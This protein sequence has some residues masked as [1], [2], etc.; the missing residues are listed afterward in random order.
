MTGQS[1]LDT[2]ARAL[3]L[4]AKGLEQ[5]AFELDDKSPMELSLDEAL[6]KPK[7]RR[8]QKASPVLPQDLESTCEIC[9][10]L[11]IEEP[12]LIPCEFCGRPLPTDA[13]EL[14]RRNCA[15]AA[16]AWEDTK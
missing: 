1:T 4:L 11:P 10:P 3:R 6:G 5:A 15:R 8:R 16:H 9:P 7:R 12:E 14:H 13:I 2:I